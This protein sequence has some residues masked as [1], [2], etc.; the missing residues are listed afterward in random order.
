M[1]RGLLLLIVVGLWGAASLA[2][3]TAQVTIERGV[4]VTVNGGIRVGTGG[5][6]YSG[7]TFA[8]LG[9]PVDGTVIYCSDCT[10]A[11]PCASGGTGAIAKRL[12]GAWRC[13]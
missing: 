1:R 11:N 4:P 12:G 6:S 7:V 10:F 8:A 5:L 13:D 3:P 9:S 2:A